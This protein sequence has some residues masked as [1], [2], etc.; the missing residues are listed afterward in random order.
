MSGDTSPGFFDP[1]LKA[2]VF[3]LMPGRF[4]VATADEVIGTLLGSCV[5]ACIHDPV[6]GLGGMNHFLLPEAGPH[7]ESSALVSSGA[8]YGAFAMES[9]INALL[10]R[11][12]SRQR[13]QVKL[14]GGARVLA[15][16]SDVGARNI[17]FVRRYVA[18]EE[19]PVIS[20]DLGGEQPRK[21]LMYPATG[22]VLVRRLP[23]VD[24]REIAVA[25][26]RYLRTMD[27]PV[28]G[29]AELF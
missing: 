13:L 19:L 16:L 4:H 5:A 27:A 15:R 23:R 14:F 25:E 9:L 11:G 18:L 22:R 6:R 10:G 3:K 2:H 8:R 17:D 24:S 20:E 1:R 7:E 28:S 29:S 21:L 26:T 12:A